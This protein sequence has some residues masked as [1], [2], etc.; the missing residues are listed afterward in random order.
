MKTR[1]FRTQRVYVRVIG[2]DVVGAR[3]PI[4]ARKLRLHDAFHF[5]C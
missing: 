4:G 5:I 2:E 1:N 3:E